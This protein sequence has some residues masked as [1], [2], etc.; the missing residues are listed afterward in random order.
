LPSQRPIDPRHVGFLRDAMA[1]AGQP[2]DIQRYAALFRYKGKLLSGD[3]SPQYCVLSEDV[4][5]QLAGALPDVK[6]VLLVRD[7]VARAWSS[8]SMAYEQGKF[9][10]RLLDS[11]DDFRDYFKRTNRAGGHSFPTQV[12]TRWARA[13]PKIPMRYFFFDDIVKD[14]GSVRDDI[15]TYIGADAKWKSGL[16]SAG[17]N[18][19]ANPS[20]L[21]PSES[22]KAI[23][24]DH[25]G[26]EVKACVGVFGE[27]ARGWAAQ[28]GL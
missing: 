8:I 26:A 17:H 27:P 24:V 18:R 1:L 20:K 4:I 15:L 11:P 16:L 23:I 19:K 2:R 14:S 12:A 25:L 22:I 13:A 7:P 6:I 9:D 21:V 28:Y 3:I 5:R 10:I